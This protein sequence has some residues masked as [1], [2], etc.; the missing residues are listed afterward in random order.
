MSREDNVHEYV[1]L[2]W[3]FLLNFSHIPSPRLYNGAINFRAV[4]KNK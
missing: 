1:Y 4:F 2:K 3:W